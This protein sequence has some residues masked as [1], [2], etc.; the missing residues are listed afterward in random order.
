M[1]NQAWG[2]GDQF[3]AAVSSLERLPLARR[4]DPV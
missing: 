3:M 2:R 1:R 4:A